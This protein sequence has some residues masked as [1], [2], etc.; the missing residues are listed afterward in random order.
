MRMSQ[1]LEKQELEKQELEK[2]VLKHLQS[3]IGSRDC[4]VAGQGRLP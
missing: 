4:R 2:I 3:A 1:E